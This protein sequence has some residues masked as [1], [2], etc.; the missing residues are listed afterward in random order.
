M[1]RSRKIAILP[2]SGIGDALLF[3]SIAQG[4]FDQGDD[5]SLFS[6]HIPQFAPWFSL[7]AKSLPPLTLAN[8]ADILTPFDAILLQ[9][10][11]SPLS[12]KIKILP[13]NI[14]TFY[15]SH[16]PSKHGTLDPH[17]DFV[18][19]PS[20][21]MVEN[22]QQ[23]HLRFFGRLAPTPNLSPPPHLVHR[24]FPQRIAIHPTASSPDKIWPKEK[25]L[26]VATLL[27]KEGLEPVFTV[28]PQERK[29]WNAP[30]FPTLADLASFLYESGAFLGN[31]SGIGHLASLLRIPH[32][33]IGGNGLQMP[34]WKTGWL[35]G[36][37]I[38][39]PRPLM[40]IKTLR[41]HW[42]LFISSRDVFNKLMD[43]I[44]N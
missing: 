4:C 19:D 15:G 10:D 26:R 8:A 11:N 20:L 41:N 28:S 42:K 40:K 24:R 13:Q 12:R 27:Q 9:H 29:L 22:I 39:P 32:L 23:A 17:K 34:L 43:V 14:F 35:P 16:N 25:F 31:D 18:C 21:P 33:T 1:H 44:R 30:L 2:A 36:T 5:P 6:P 37:L 7:P 3:Q 38:T